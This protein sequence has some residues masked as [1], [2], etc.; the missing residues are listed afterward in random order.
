MY[1]G[2]DPTLIISVA[3]IGERNR[4][5]NSIL[6][7]TMAR[8]P[9]ETMIRLDIGGLPRNPR[10]VNKKELERRIQR[11][12]NHS[13]VVTWTRD[14]DGLV[15][16]SE[17]L[18]NPDGELRLHLDYRNPSIEV[19]IKYSE[20]LHAIQMSE[21]ARVGIARPPSPPLQS[22]I[23]QSSMVPLFFRFSGHYRLPASPNTSAAVFRHLPN[24]VNR[25]RI[26]VAPWSQLLLRLLR[27]R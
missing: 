17:K 26:A 10:P 16:T 11:I 27:K 22:S 6:A 19:A 9:I 13:E 20:I 23:L 15:T 14:G 1:Y 2:D 7:H 24:T 5:A 3:A 18:A 4:P 21:V 25:A 12:I 8:H